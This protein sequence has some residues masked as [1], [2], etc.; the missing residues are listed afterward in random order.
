MTS[1][2]CCC[3]EKESGIDQL[4]VAPRFK[5]VDC[6]LTKS[7]STFNVTPNMDQNTTVQALRQIVSEFV[8]ERDWHQFHNPKNLSMALSI[9]V[10]E[11]MEHFQW[12]SGEE[13]RST[14]PDSQKWLDIREELADVICYTLA[15][16]NELQIDVSEAL[17][18]KMIKNRKKYPVDEYRGRY[19][20]EDATGKEP[21]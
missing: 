12:I 11:L 17:E 5:L 6:E 21:N 7:G 9:E 14:E 8:T 16:A 2:S 18:D 1:E 15:L 19:G 13:A 10:G 20:P 4:K 3:L